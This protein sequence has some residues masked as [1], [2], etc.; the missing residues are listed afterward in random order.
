MTAHSADRTPQGLSP[1]GRYRALW[2]RYGGGQWLIFDIRQPIGREPVP[3]A[4][5]RDVPGATPELALRVFAQEQ[6]VR[7]E[8]ARLDEMTLTIPGRGV[9]VLRLGTGDTTYQAV[10]YQQLAGGGLRR[11]DLRTP[12]RET[13]VE[14]YA[15]AVRRLLRPSFEASEAARRQRRKDEGNVRFRLTGMRG[16]R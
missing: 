15:A 6:A 1:C 16:G 12:W 4:A 2:S 8:A 11:S 5:Y 7:E 14:A 3:V 9:F 10:I 13:P